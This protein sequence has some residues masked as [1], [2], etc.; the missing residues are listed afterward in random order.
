MPS[1]GLYGKSGTFARKSNQFF[2]SFFGAGGGTYL[3]VGANI[4]LTTIPLAQNPL[5]NCIAFEPEPTNARSFKD[6]TRLNARH[7]NVRFHE[8]ALY[9]E[10]ATL[11]LS[12]SQDGNLGDH[13]ISHQPAEQS[14]IS[15]RGAPLDEVVGTITSPLAAKIDV[16]GAE[17]FVL[18][19]GASTLA[20]VDALAIE[21]SPFH[22]ALLNADG[23]KI[24]DYLAGFARL[25]CVTGDSD[26]PLEFGPTEPVLERLRTRCGNRAETNSFT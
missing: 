23:T 10:N 8:V 25:A 7:E 12:L 24:V 11:S 21:F 17:P 22:M 20:R 9:H 2:V 15:V 18:A 14:T 3:D 4:G 26:E 16:Q 5:V 1:L 6:N 19:G 13:R